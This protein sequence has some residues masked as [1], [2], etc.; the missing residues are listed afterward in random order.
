MAKALF[1]TGQY[2]I[3]L[4]EGH[5]FPHQKYAMVRGFLAEE[6]SFELKPAPLAKQNVI[7]L[8]HHPDYVSQFL[9]G[10]LPASAIRRIGFPWSEMLVKRSLASVGGTLSAAVAALDTGWGVTLGGGTHHARR[11]AGARQAVGRRLRQHDEAD[12]RR[13]Q[14]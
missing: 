2:S 6:G 8:A 14:W 12:R 4:P 11:S 7:E 5:K 3:S 1:Y 10:A 13:G 9:S